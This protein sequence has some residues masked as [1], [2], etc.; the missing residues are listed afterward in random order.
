M[1]GFMLPY[2][3]IIAL[4]LSLGV[5][6][7]LISISLG[8]IKTKGRMKI[9]VAFACAEAIMPLIGLYIG[10]VA[11]QL[12]GNWASFIGGLL[13]LGVAIWLI[14]FEKEDEAE[15][16]LER[17]LV[18]WTLI[19]TAISISLDELAVGLSIGFIDVPIA[20]STM[21][22]ALQAFVFTYVGLTFGSQIKPYLGEWSEKIGGIALGLLGIWVIIESLL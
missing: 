18:G 15:G 16:K 7:L 3:K 11:G 5:D 2:F 20:L 6:T 22:I 12:I 21:L 13:L 4:V 8:V 17:H 14:F 19:M 9:A 10:K 1:I